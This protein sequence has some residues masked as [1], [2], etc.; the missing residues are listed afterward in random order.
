M[1]PLSAILFFFV[2]L[3][4][5]SLWRNHATHAATLAALRAQM[6]RFISD[7]ESEKDTRRRS[8]TAIV[9]RIRILEGQ[10]PLPNDSEEN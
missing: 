8:N 3:C 5:V 9:S 4:L 7:I 2:A 6:G 1:D 10:K